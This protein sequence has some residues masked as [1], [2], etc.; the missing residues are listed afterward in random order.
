MA[1]FG[2]Y[3]GG[4]TIIAPR[5]RSGFGK[6]PAHVKPKLPEVIPAL[7][8]PKWELRAR[9]RR[10][11]IQGGTGPSIP[12]VR[13][14]P[15]TPFEVTLTEYVKRCVEA[16]ESGSPRPGAPAIVSQRLGQRLKLTLKAL[17]R[18]QARKRS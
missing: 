8:G 16:D 14:R 15:A 13:G 6:L 1:R 3:N 7:P 12:E 5:R 9:K 18:A 4:G 17:V 11:G 10:K 2:T